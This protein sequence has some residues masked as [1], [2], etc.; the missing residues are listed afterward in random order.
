MPNVRGVRA[1]WIFVL[2]KHLVHISLPNVS[3]TLNGK[4][5]ERATCATRA[6]L[7]ERNCLLAPGF[8]D[9]EERDRREADARTC[10]SHAP[11]ACTPH[12]EIRARA[13]RPASGTRLAAAPVPYEKRAFR[14]AALA[15]PRMGN[16]RGTARGQW[17]SQPAAVRW[18]S[19]GAT[20]GRVRRKKRLAGARRLF[21]HHWSLSAIPN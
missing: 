7:A 11:H 12:A 14:L 6:D 9:P 8:G 5:T 19:I 15:A 3:K 20:I 16:V 21:R 4:C 1:R 10:T 13:P 17:G 2:K 18:G